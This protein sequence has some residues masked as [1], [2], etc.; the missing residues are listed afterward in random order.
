[1]LLGLALAS[2]GAVVLSCSQVIGLA[3]VERVECVLDC[4]VSADVVVP[5]ASRDAVAHKDGGKHTDSGTKV[6]TGLPPCTA[7]TQC[8]T[9][10]NPR[11]DVSTGACVACLPQ[12]DN[13]PL[14]EICK[15]VGAAYA[16]ATGCNTVADCPT[17]GGSASDSGGSVDGGAEAGGGGGV[18]LACCDHVCVDT[19]SSAA[20]CGGCGQA[21]SSENIT[22]P[23]CAAGVCAGTCSAGFS[24]CDHDKLTNGCET[25][26]EGTDIMNCG[27][28]GTVCSAANI[29][30]VT[31]TAGVCDGACNSGFAD[32]N[33]NKQT[34]GCE[35]DTATSTSNCGAC[36]TVCSA[37]NIPTV[38]CGGGV[39]N[40][41][42]AAGFADCDMNKQTN[43]CEVD[44]NTS[45]T[46]CGMCGK[47]CGG[48][49]AC[50]SGACTGCLTGGKVPP[51]VCKTG[52]DATYGSPY[53][54]CAASC[55]SAWLSSD[56]GAVDTT[57]YNALAICNS[58]GYAT[59]GDWAGNWGDTC[60]SSAAASPGT[61]CS[62]VGSPTWSTPVTSEP[63]FYTVEWQC[64]P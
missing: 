10:A 30:T 48:T 24:D 25:N 17:D 59:T 28:C 38:S 36:G 58:L 61:S 29:A 18:T 16:C 63:I 21:C 34:D 49:I 1:L 26:I 41:A 6:D 50:V 15:A 4:G 37:N 51:A 11:C 14:G 64:L 27:G 22:T 53:V 3:G 54:V 40:G 5:D 39:C 12:T 33:M 47:V 42:C 19:G 9:A 52:T 20:N 35:I 32:C 43:G 8:T 7:D 31:C 57:Q 2:L 44:T 62:A 60:G 45:A 55:A 23:I 56:D 46:N 13:C